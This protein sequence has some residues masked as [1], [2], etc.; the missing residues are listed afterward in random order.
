MSEPNNSANYSAPPNFNVIDSFPPN[1][2][3]ISLCP[4]WSEQDTALYSAGVWLQS[5]KSSSKLTMKNPSR[6][7]IQILLL[8]SGQ[9]SPN[10][11]PVRFPCKVCDKPVKSN[12][13]GLQCD[14]CMF[15]IHTKCYGISA[16][17]YAELQQSTS[18]WHCSF[19]SVVQP[20][21]PPPQ[22][23]S[24]SEPNRP[25]SIRFPCKVC[26][27]PVKSNQ[28]GLQCDSCMFWLHTKC[29]GISAGT[30]T[31][32]QQSTSLWHCSFCS[33]VPP[34]GENPAS[35]PPHS[36]TSSA[37]SEDQSAADS[38]SHLKVLQLNFN[39][40]KSNAK[41]AELNLLI[42]RH[43]PDI[44]IGCES[45]LDDSFTTHSIIPETYDVQRSDRNRNGGGVLLAIKDNLNP[46]P[47]TK[48]DTS[49]NL[50][51]CSIKPN[52]GKKILIGSFYRPPDDSS[53]D[54]KPLN[55]SLAKVFS[56]RST[57]TVVLAG[58][59]NASGTSWSDDLVTRNDTCSDAIKKKL[60][61]IADR[62]GLS[63]LHDEITRPDSGSCLDLVFCNNPNGVQNIST[64]AGMGDHLA[65]T[66]QIPCAVP[67]TH[68]PQRKV[69][70]YQKAN[71]E[72]IKTDIKLFQD[73]FSS[74]WTDHSPEDNWKRLHHALET[75][76]SKNIPQTKTGR[77]N[78]LPW[79]THSV[80]KHM[81]R[82]DRSLKKA[83]RRNTHS[84]WKAYRTQR[85]ATTNAIRK[86]HDI[87]IHDIIGNLTEATPQDSSTGIKRF[88]GY[89]KATRK[90][91][92]GIPTL[93]HQDSKITSDQEKADVMNQQ[94][95]DAFTNERLTDI[96]NLGPSPH[97]SCRN[98]TFT[99]PGIVKLLQGLQ[100]HKA[101]GPDSV[102]PRIL[103]D[104]AQELGPILTVFFQQIYDSGTTP[105]DWRDANVVPIYK[106]G[107]R[108]Q[109][110]NYRPVSLTS[111]LSKCYEHILCSSIMRHLEERGI[112]TE[113]QHGFRSGRSTETQLLAS[114]HD[115]S[116]SLN[117]AGQTDVVFL[118]FSKAFDCVPHQRLLEKLRFY[119]IDGKLNKVIASLL[120]GRRQRVVINGTRSEWTNVTS[121]V[122]QGTVIGPILFLI[123]INDIQQNITSKMRLFADDSTIY[124]DIKTRE[125]HLTLQEDLRRLDEWAEKWQMVFKPSKCYV[126][127]ISNKH[128]I[129]QF[130]Y[131]IKDSPLTVT[132]THTYLGVEIDNKMTWS[133]QCI[134]AKKKAARTLGLI[135][136]TLHAA[137]R[138][139]RETAYKVLVRPKLEY[140]TTAWSPHTSGK[141]KLL[142]S[143]Q[144]KAARFV[145]REYRR[146][147]KGADLVSHLNWDK[148]ETRRK[149]KDAVMFFKVHHQLVQL[150]FPPCVIPKPR[151]GF[152]DHPLAYRHVWSRVDAYKFSYFIRAIPLWNG[153]P[154][155]AV[156]ATLPHS[157]QPLALAHFRAKAAAV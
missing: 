122:P 54:L 48:L 38:S 104:L 142:E 8:V 83:K 128:N 73:S 155:T 4:N 82:R 26:D 148:L 134:S 9:V 97:P 120:S 86:S 6:T 72:A 126:M 42:Q 85:N 110:E 66:Y 108:H 11:G 144:N 43:D 123:Y 46:T 147:K 50:R 27:K 56:N 63:Q 64:V 15:W 91:K 114:A 150:P 52:R 105:Q 135:Q 121:G 154:A 80:R 77:R 47:E 96:P 95:K 138:A 153:L 37:C 17:T 70:R 100:P 79:I 33:N 74:N 99:E 125:D 141:V 21:N 1:P 152:T 53:E 157:F 34:D 143:V 32:L 30:Y 44:I 124:R 7:S 102:P 87:Y 94:F 60:T 109:P 23:G 107:N 68:T 84:A 115:W 103:K 19:C 112:L 28:K 151:L 149:T 111:V 49:I 113:D 31:E 45:K 133:A 117:K 132:T 75:T 93:H 5:T 90:Q 145:T 106:K 16:G 139:C 78:N 156:A 22:P 89:V 130:T 40:L 119:G 140:A 65:L 101:A 25:K 88:F 136:R 131:T 76:M 2:F 67:R 39:S 59:F 29:I 118:D 61:G 116:E 35:T 58:D 127:N 18:E 71:M 13:K 36:P 24:S 57:P 10:P 55:D 146:E 20:A 3:Q 69:Y 92:N 137:P 12:Q 41:K 98:I 129:S 81:K 14:S 62:F 51:W